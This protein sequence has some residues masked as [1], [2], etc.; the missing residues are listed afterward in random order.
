M[1]NNHFEIPPLLGLAVA[2]KL[3]MCH[4][5]FPFKQC[6]I[7]NLSICF[8]CCCNFH[9]LIEMEISIANIHFLKTFL[10]HRAGSPVAVITGWGTRGRGGGGGGVMV[11]ITG[12]GMDGWF[13]Q[14][15]WL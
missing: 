6:P 13:G 11:M 4:N 5:L 9:D 15:T 10:P 12:E 3:Q 2:L 1:R 8:I 14:D 7:L